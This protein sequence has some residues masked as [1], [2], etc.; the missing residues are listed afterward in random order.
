[1]KIHY[2]TIVVVLAMT[3]IPFI[4]AQ[5]PMNVTPNIVEYTGWYNV[6]PGVEGD[7]DVSRYLCIKRGLGRPTLEEVFRVGDILEAF[8]KAEHIPKEKFYCDPRVDDRTIY[9]GFRNLDDYT[10]ERLKKLEEVL[11]RKTPNWRIIVWGTLDPETTVVVYP[12]KIAYSMQGKEEEIIEKIK[13]ELAVYEDKTEGAMHRQ[14]QWVEHLLQ[15]NAPTREALESGPMVIA[16]FG[17]SSGD[18]TECCLWIVSGGDGYQGT[19]GWFPEYAEGFLGRT[20]SEFVLT[21]ERKLVESFDVPRAEYY[22]QVF[23]VC[24][25]KHRLPKRIRLEPKRYGTGP[26][27]RIVGIALAEID[28]SAME[29]LSDAELKTKSATHIS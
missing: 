28:I 13:S 2:S 21:T 29:V 10:L 18:E 5:E 22:C 12:S 9:L 11:K 3:L 1:M 24:Y 26:P 16:V 27:E 20:G 23:A 6:D 14:K 17:N 7:D 25:E 8:A 15:A 4:H 19:V